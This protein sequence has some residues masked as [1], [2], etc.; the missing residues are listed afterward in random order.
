MKTAIASF[1][2]FVI[3]FGGI[4][5]GGYLYLRSRREKQK[6]ERARL[7][8]A[9]EERIRKETA[10]TL[11]PLH[12]AKSLGFGWPLAEPEKTEKEV[13]AETREQVAKAVE[14]EIPQAG[15][16]S[17]FRQEARK[18]FRYCQPGEKVTI[19]V[20]DQKGGYS[21]VRGVLVAVAEDRVHIG[22]RWISRLDIVEEQWVHFDQDLSLQRITAEVNAKQGELAKVREAY[23]RK[24]Q[25]GF[26]RR[27]FDQAGYTFIEAKA[28]WR[29]KV[30]VAAEEREKRIKALRKRV[31]KEEYTA[32]GYILR[33]EEN[34]WDRKTLL[35]LLR[36]KAEGAQ[37]PPAPAA[38]KEEDGEEEP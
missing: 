27:L 32:H 3:L 11:Q 31:E 33:P 7:E 2:A 29:P 35:E 38:A 10:E 25:P 18:R 9:I 30:D 24:I 19:N 37:E 4:G 26:R 6:Q 16:A 1:L 20:R 15:M 8:E 23:R 14:A 36:D 13:E 28:Q 5:G 22:N 21:P 34:S 17:R 12:V